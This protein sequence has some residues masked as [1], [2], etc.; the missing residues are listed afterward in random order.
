MAKQQ[1]M[2]YTKRA[3]FNYIAA[4]FNIS[5]ITARILINRGIKENEIE[6]FLHGSSLHSPWLLKGMEKAVKLTINCILQNKK[7]RI[8]GDYDIDGICSTYILYNAL[9]KLTLNID[10][11]IPDRIKDGYGINENI[12][13]KAKKDNVEVII[14]CDNGIAAFEALELARKYNMTL[15]LTDHHE[16]FKNEDKTDRLPIANV[17]LNPK[18]SDCKYPFKSICGA[19]VAFKYMKALYEYLEKSNS[20]MLKNIDSNEVIEDLTEF[21]AVATIGDIMPLRDENRVVV[22]KG[23]LKLKHTKNIGLL[24]LLRAC[25]LEGKCINSYHIGFIVGPCLNASGR[26]ASAKLALRLLNEKEP[27]KAEK[28]AYELKEL[29]DERKDKTVNGTLKAIELAEDKFLND[30]V[31]VI[32][33]ED[34]HESIAGIIAGRLREKYQKPS[35]VITDTEDDLIKGSARSIENYN[36]FEKL[37]EVKELF[38]KFGGHPMA[39]GMSLEKKNLEVLRTRLN[40]NANLS[41]EDFIEKIWIDVALPF[42][43]ISENLIS[44]FEILEP[45]GQGNEKPIFAQK[46]VEILSLDVIGKNKNAVK[47]SLKDERGFV[48]KGIIFMDGNIFKEE[49]NNARYIDILY[50]PQINEFN[51]RKSIQIVIKGWKNSVK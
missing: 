4:R 47:L 3:D 10:Y 37:C 35:I 49:L 41:E 38:T 34:C 22:K 43:F 12:I 2:L 36:M 31:L 1:W 14:T 48:I 40:E 45:F 6:S 30:S 8:V 44:E 33:L 46:S 25:E 27:L 39:A 15:I 13:E 32:Y 16:V 23:L 51:G 17:I 18:Q 21:V 19:M 50:Y 11:E 9:S 29:N 42:E 20:L 7:I 24:S 5:P 28:L 26:L